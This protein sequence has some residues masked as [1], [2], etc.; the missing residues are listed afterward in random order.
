MKKLAN[1]EPIAKGGA[2][3]IGARGVGQ[4]GMLTPIMRSV[5]AMA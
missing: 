1:S 3:G 2:E 5:T 4:N